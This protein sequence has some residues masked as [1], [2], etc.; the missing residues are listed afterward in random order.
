[1]VGF[2]QIGE[3]LVRGFPE[4][5]ETSEGS[6][7]AS[8]Y[9]ALTADEVLRRKGSWRVLP[10]MACCCCLND[11]LLLFKHEYSRPRSYVSH[12]LGLQADSIES[13]GASAEAAS[14]LTAK[15]E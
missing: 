8:S 10:M 14:C 3:V 4:R 12:R 7:G 15:I 11:V 1:M 5:G 6:A 9:M 13:F 2:A